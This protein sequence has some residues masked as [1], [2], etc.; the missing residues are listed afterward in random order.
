MLKVTISHLWIG[1]LTIITNFSTVTNNIIISSSSSSSS[2]NNLSNNDKRKFIRISNH[3]TTTRILADDNDNDNDDDNSAS[4]TVQD[5]YNKTSNTIG[6]VKDTIHTAPVSWTRNQWY[7]ILIMVG[8]ALV[9]FGCIYRCIPCA[10]R[11]L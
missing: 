1:I 10:P 5:I 3:D 11:I 4:S 8:S 7:I 9:L 2:M 6:D